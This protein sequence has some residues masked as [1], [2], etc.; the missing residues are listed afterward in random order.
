MQKRPSDK[1]G[2]S[3]VAESPHPVPIV[4]VGA[5]AGGIKALKQFFMTVPE[6]LGTAFVVVLHLN[7]SSES[8]LSE[9][10][11]KSVPM[12]VTPVTAPTAVE[13]DHVYV[14]QPDQTLKVENGMLVTRKRT[15]PPGQHYPV[16]ELFRSVAV[17]CEERAIAVVLS[18]TGLDGSRAITTLREHGGLV[19]VQDPGTAEFPEMPEN[20]IATGM[21]DRVLP[22]SAMC[23]E[24]GRY[25]DHL[26]SAIASSPK[27][28][29]EQTD[30]VDGIIGLVDARSH[31]NFGNYKKATLLR[32]IQRRA[33]LSSAPNLT[34]YAQLLKE[35]P[36]ELDALVNDLLISVTRFN[37]DPEAWDVLEE[38]ALKPLV[39][40]QTADRPIRAWAVGCA[41]GEEAY[42]LAMRIAE[43]AARQDR[44][45]YCDIFAT[46][47]S[48]TALI[49]ARQGVY[50]L[51]AIEELSPAQRRAFFSVEGERVRIA[52]TLR[53]MIVFARQNVVKDPPFSQL[54]IVICRNLL[55]Y[56]A[57]DTQERIVKLFH[58]ALREGGTLFLGSAENVSGRD[59]L[60]QAV[61]H[62]WRIFRRIG[63][64][65]H[66][67]MEFPAGAD[68]ILPRRAA[69]ETSNHSTP[70]RIAD[71][72]LRALANRH[73]PP[74]VVVDQK[75][76]VLYFHGDTRPFLAQPS[77]E[78]TQN[79]LA[80]A[81]RGLR[82]RLRS[83][84]RQARETGAAF[85]TRGRLARVDGASEPIEIEASPIESGRDR[86]LI[87]VSFRTAQSAAQGAA[88]EEAASS[89]ENELE[90]EVTAL[91]E[92]LRSTLDHSQQAQE[93][94]KA[95][96]EEVTSMNEELRSSNEELES[97][98]EELQSLNEELNTLNTQLHHKMEELQQSTSDIK[99]LLSSSAV[100]TLFLDRDLRI[101]WF[102]PT[103][104]PLFNL[105]ASDVSRPISDLVARL[106][107]E[108]FGINCRA[109]LETLTPSEQHVRD[110][111]GRSY[112]RRILPYR[113]DDDRIDG[114]VITF[115][116]V[117]EIQS[118][119]E[120]AEQIV[121]TVP[122]PLV[123]LGTDLH[124]V[125]ANSAFYAKFDVTKQETEGRQIFELGN[126]QWN[127][128][129]LRRLL[130]EIL[131]D[132]HSFNA[133][134]VEHE[135]R[136]IGRRSMMLNGRRLDGV[137]LILLAIED[138]TERIEAQRHQNVLAA[139]L[140]HRVKN[141]LTVVQA[142]ASQTAAHSTS[143]EEFRTVFEG[144]LRAFAQAHVRLM[145]HSWEGG[146]LCNI[147]Q[148]ALSTHAIDQERIE[149]TA[150]C[151]VS[152][153]AK[154]VLAL[155]LVLHE[156]ATNASKYG[157][158][159][160]DVGRVCVSWTVEATEDGRE[161]HLRWQ[162]IGGPK[163]E[164]PK[165]RGFG[166][167]LIEQAMEYE[168]G[169]KG[170]LLFDAEGLQCELV[171]PTS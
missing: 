126:G 18:G 86:Q 63:S 12:P 87:L 3:F 85:T 84:V 69:L 171:F 13:I 19:I 168:L 130:E 149:I 91:R 162:E 97:S 139:E 26:R 121:E 56:L 20:A 103:V 133:H 154:A 9:I 123:V 15:A 74:S 129:E 43:E 72:S 53:K 50:G 116:E 142:F 151:R 110:D 22:P 119:R 150:G 2:V 71:A 165:R 137:Q 170:R 144:R 44:P 164:P 48:E 83:A 29:D 27:A 28:A 46:D 68:R 118:Q 117:T 60:F 41:T 169:G 39:A 124:V 54:D 40:A 70:I 66:D 161:V 7:P 88:A 128:P 57:S 101:R 24:I 112:L 100:A 106:S 6:R 104:V 131:P 1:G 25:L 157:A 152:L 67:L 163:I 90:A 108:S 143:F 81:N 38:Q 42:T 35:R 92:E 36:P 11:S 102:S 89:R 94:L 146:Q 125:S 55:I 52:Q 96:N 4:A 156:L 145:E 16:D 120:Y 134:L 167:K 30:C 158:L 148:H 47:I 45:L 95:S 37:R 105:I 17:E 113:T 93:D 73:A 138:V 107:D 147:I 136:S 111:Q 98:K 10:L 8:H 166:T 33:G 155:N 141:A 61:S 62:K 65:R 58:F 34:D 77:G 159:F 140:N 114:L 109:V 59:H 78:A 82:T 49:T 23:E 32:R 99:N 127:I 153:S 76:D 64:T 132:N 51:A 80:L 75:M 21:V 31:I 5:S 79:L 122:M 14:L 160:R 135:F 115:V